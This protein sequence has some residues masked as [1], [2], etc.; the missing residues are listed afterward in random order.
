MI[1]SFNDATLLI[2]LGAPRTGTTWMSNYF[3]THPDVL[4]SP[5]PSLRYF[6]ERY[7]QRRSG[8]RSANF[9]ARLAELERRRAKAKPGAADFQPGGVW[10]A[11]RDRMDMYD[12]DSAYIEYFRKRWT[13]EAVFCEI[14]P[15]YSVLSSDIFKIMAKTHPRVRF[16]F[17]MRNPI[18]RFW[19]GLKLKNARAP[20]VDIYRDF[21]E[22]WAKTPGGSQGYVETIRNLEKAVDPAAVDYVFFEDLF[23]TA[24]ERT[25]ADLCAFLGV[26]AMAGNTG[27]PV[28]QT[29]TWPLDPERRRIIFGKFARV[30]KSVHDWREGAI[31]R[32]WLDDMERFTPP[33]PPP[34]R[35]AP[36][37]APPRPPPRFGVLH[38]LTAFSHRNVMRPPERSRHAERLKEIGL[39]PMPH[40]F[41]SALAVVS[42]ID[43]ST[44][45]RYD[46]YT[47]ILVDRL[48]LDF[49]DSTWLQRQYVRRG[50]SSRYFN[51]ATGFFSHYFGI[52]AGE[53]P[54]MFALARTFNEVLAEYHRGNVDH[55]HA[56]LPYGARVVVAETLVRKAGG[57]CLEFGDF[58]AKGPLNCRN[59]FLFC[60]C[61]IARRGAPVEVGAI[62]V[63]QRDGQRFTGYSPA[64]FPDAEDG[65]AQRLFTLQSAPRAE[66]RAP[67]IIDI[68][69]LR[70]DF[71]DPAHADNVERVLLINTPGELIL[72]RLEYL[73][74]I[75]NVEM[76][77]ITDH[78]AYHFRNAT[79]SVRR[80]KEQAAHVEAHR[81]TVEAL[82]GTVRDDHGD[83]VFSTDADDPRS[84]CRVLPEA[85]AKFGVRFVV[86]EGNTA[87][88][89]SGWS[90]VDV[91]TP[92]LTRAGGGVY[93]ARRSLPNVEA[94]AH[95]QRFDDQRSF[96]GT[97][98]PRISRVIAETEENPGLFWPIYTHLG[99]L[100]HHG[101]G[102]RETGQRWPLPS[103]YFDLGP[104]NDLQN[105][106]FGITGAAPPAARIW[107]TRASVLYDFAL[108][109]RSAPEHTERPDANTVE[110][111]SWH[112]PV[113]DK[114]LP[115]SPA[116]LYGL[117]F[118]V[119]DPAKA[120]V[121]LDGRAL[122]VLTRNPADATG[123]P[124]VTVAECEIRAPVFDR[125]DPAA[126]LPAQ[127]ALEGK[128]QFS[129]SGAGEP[130]HGR[131]RVD[132]GRLASL[133][134]PM[135]G[136]VAPGA[137]LFTLRL[138]RGAG[139]LFGVSMETTTGGRFFFGDR[140]V[141][142][143]A[144]GAP[145]AVYLFEQHQP[146]DDWT[147]LTAPFHDLAWT[148]GSEPGGPAPSHPLAAITLICAGEAGAWID[149]AGPAFLRP[150]ATAL[151]SRPSP[152][153]CLG[154]SIPAFSP[155]QIVQVRPAEGDGFGEP[156][157]Q[158]VDQRG[159]FCFEGLPVGV[160]RLSSTTEAGE[161]H[162]R[163]GPLV[164]LAGDVTGL[165]LD[166]R[167][168]PA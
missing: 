59:L 21:D 82:R 116:Q 120:V 16:I 78:A 150:R 34:R 95:G 73:R 107:F 54:E 97:F 26:S 143:L 19:S 160:Y 152:L 115:R 62:T 5:I 118:H 117:T 20:A 58:D 102:E 161:V 130:A 35:A 125:L 52:E 94:P 86:P 15:N 103:P 11:L 18:D 9:E 70:L 112:D 127:I 144:A 135:H 159:F 149:F 166:R 79:A 4:M 64:A 50:R 129:D 104:L 138:R 157:S 156:Q 167:V 140:A 128:W 98:V 63:G 6:D 89:V 90:A 51:R 151:S 100:G 113:L 93:V 69:D 81:G 67:A 14:S 60:V 75:Y 47:G 101:D 168:T 71:L 119:D 76:P 99:S 109:M 38:D 141:L 80:D 10:Q 163:R 28:N 111:A 139:G 7:A 17:A 137:Q 68:V 39:R 56:Y 87:S 123:R 96:H 25:V 88:S 164:E 146:S 158:T 13:G 1:S 145:T 33:P 45:N 31:P 155:G 84:L 126:N 142:D 24:P 53:P 72:R 65:R 27:V 162:D 30:F 55:F 121:R 114:T 40:P 85:S 108:M 92:A 3:A 110:I 22:K 48:G 41:A 32:S 105:R 49:G 2:G 44:R 165:V 133:R 131:L 136:W 77:L 37:R 153:H 132:A 23:H 57:I 154:G 124:S 148:P 8:Q 43:G 91:V 83:L 61:V 12:D 66:T 29:E 134:W 106:A 147:T 36:P 122:E 74:D 42:D 46:G